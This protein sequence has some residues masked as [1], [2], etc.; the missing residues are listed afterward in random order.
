LIGAQAGPTQT[1]TTKVIRIQRQLT[2]PVNAKPKIAK[3]IIIQ[4][5][6]IKISMFAVSSL[7]LVTIGWA[8][9]KQSRGIKQQPNKTIAIIITAFCVFIFSPPKLFNKIQT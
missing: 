6:L 9:A 5:T 1:A 8:K 7:A 4:L 2:L 3:H